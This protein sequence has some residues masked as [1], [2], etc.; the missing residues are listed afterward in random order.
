MLSVMIAGLVFTVPVGGQAQSPFVPQAI[1]ISGSAFSFDRSGV[2]TTPAF[3]ENA[4][5][6]RPT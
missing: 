1:A 4:P 5:H 3:N 6:R 2:G